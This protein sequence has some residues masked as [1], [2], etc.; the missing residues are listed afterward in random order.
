MHA[1]HVLRNQLKSLIKCKLLIHG[2]GIFVDQSLIRVFKV[3]KEAKIR[4]Q[5]NQVPHLTQD[6]T[7]KSDKTQ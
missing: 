5:Y 6:T 1:K 4:G 2:N 3:S 7:R